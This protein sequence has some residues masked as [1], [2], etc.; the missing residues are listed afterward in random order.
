MDISVH[1][2]KNIALNTNNT[3]LNLINLADVLNSSKFKIYVLEN[4]ALNSDP[5]AFEIITDNWGKIISLD[6]SI[7]QPYLM[8]LFWKNLSSNPNIFYLHIVN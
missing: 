2:Y 6:N 7:F 5:K 8:I 1:F 4:L 3:I